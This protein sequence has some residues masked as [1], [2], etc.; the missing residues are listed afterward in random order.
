MLGVHE[1]SLPFVLATSPQQVTEERRLLYVGVTRA[2][3]VLRISWS[4]TRNGGGNPRK[5]SRFL[6]PV[7]PES[8]RPRPGAPTAPRRGRGRGT[9]LSAHCRACG[10][11]LD[12]AAERKLGRH[13]DC[14]ATFDE[15]TVEQLREWRRRGGR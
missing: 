14:P 7:L 2:K 9:V 5:P 3:R 12:D 6:D 1:G 15:A 4:R 10:R 8:L 11:A 13:A